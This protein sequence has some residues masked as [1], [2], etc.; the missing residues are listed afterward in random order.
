MLVEAK[1]VGGHKVIHDGTFYYTFC[2]FVENGR[3]AR[4]TSVR[5]IL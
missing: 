5:Q 1:V 4:G 3:V 2:R